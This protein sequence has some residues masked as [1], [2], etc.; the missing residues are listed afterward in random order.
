M[1]AI[2]YVEFTKQLMH[3]S[4]DYC[5][6]LAPEAPLKAVKDERDSTNYADAYVLY[7][8]KLI[9]PIIDFFDFFTAY[10]RDCSNK[11]FDSCIALRVFEHIPVRKIDWFLYQLASIMESGAEL[12]IVV[13]DMV[14]VA[15][16]LVEASKQLLTEK[17]D[18]FRFLRLNYELLSEGN[19]VYD[20]HST[21]TD[22]HSI[23]YLLEMENLF[24]VVDIQKVRLDTDIVPHELYVRAIRNG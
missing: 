23:T 9:V 16:A 8:K 3:L 10:K 2:S 7:N 24:Q 13:P 5:L 6:L 20:R 14:A 1:S 12:H 11:L 18:Y 4:E 17:R 22:E 19:H 21:W 15:N